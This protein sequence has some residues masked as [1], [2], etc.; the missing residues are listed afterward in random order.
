MSHNGL[1]LDRTLGTVASASLALGLYRVLSKAIKSDGGKVSN[2]NLLHLVKVCL[3]S[4][5]LGKSNVL[6]DIEY[7]E[8]MVQTGELVKFQGSCH[9]RSVLFTVSSK[10]KKKE[11]VNFFLEFTC[12]VF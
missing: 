8:E 11:E 3:G 6:Q 1:S 7:M 10:K 9:C 5:M 4:L 2:S 12:H